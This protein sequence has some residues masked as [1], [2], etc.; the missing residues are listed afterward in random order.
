[1][2]NPDLIIHKL[3][4]ALPGIYEHI[5]NED[6][7]R[8]AGI[9]KSDLDKI[10][11]S[12]AHYLQA[13]YDPISPPPSD[14][15]LLGSAVHCAVLEPDTF[16]DRFVEKPVFN[17]RAKDGKAAAEAWE[18]ERGNRIGLDEDT[19]RAVWAMRDSLM[20][21]PIIAKLVEGSSHE[22]SIFTD[23]SSVLCKCRPDG[24]SRDEGYMIDLKTTRDAS[25]A[26]FARDVAKF[27]YHVQEAWYRMVA[28]EQTGQPVEAFYF[29]AVENTPP[30]AVAIYQLDPISLEVGQRAAIQDLSTF[31]RAVET[32]KWDAYPRTI[33]QLSLP[34]W[35]LD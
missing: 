6:Y 3:T 19:M 7:H 28:V 13:L 12:P 27:R 24:W 2:T 9:S 26:E 16:Y 32:G 4:G 21:N 31:K 20:A 10:H 34:R 29:L 18:A 35:A 1:M 22:V 25:P 33:Q 11:R 23:I 8:G 17:R 5:S 30:Y 14:S 15:M